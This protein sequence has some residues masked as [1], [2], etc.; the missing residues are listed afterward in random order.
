MGLGSEGGKKTNYGREKEG[1]GTND[2]RWKVDGK[3]RVERGKER[4]KDEM[5]LLVDAIGIDPISFTTSYFTHKSIERDRKKKK[6]GGGGSV[7]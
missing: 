5:S 2:S 7:R 1:K 4:G 6:R 3:T